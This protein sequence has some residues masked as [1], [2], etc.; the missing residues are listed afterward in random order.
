VTLDPPQVCG[1]GFSCDNYKLFSLQKP[2]DFTEIIFW[3]D[4]L[5]VSSN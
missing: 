3:K 5:A 4:I 2:F 1:S